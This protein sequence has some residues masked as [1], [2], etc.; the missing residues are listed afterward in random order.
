MKATKNWFSGLPLISRLTVFALLA[1]AWIGFVVEVAVALS[2]SEARMQAALLALRSL[3]LAVALML[4]L[5]LSKPTELLPWA[6]LFVAVRLGDIFAGVYGRQA[7][8]FIPSLPLAVS[9][10]GC[11]IPLLGAR[12]ERQSRDE[13]QASKR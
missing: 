6:L 12:L 9:L 7:L 8:R 2:A 10:L 1:N 5:G 4:H 11:L 3:A 13:P